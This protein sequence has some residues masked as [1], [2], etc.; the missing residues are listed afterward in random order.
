MTRTFIY[1]RHVTAL[2]LLTLSSLGIADEGLPSLE[3]RWQ[4]ELVAARYQPI[5]LILTITTSA[6]DQYTG[7]LDIPSQFQ[8]GV[9]VNPFSP[10]GNNIT[11]RVPALQVEFYG[12][13]VLNDAGTEVLA[14]EGDWS[15]SGEYVPLRLT[16]A[17]D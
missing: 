12:N 4:G 8:A 3:G 6:D 13:L 9:P 15:Q 17:A 16:P 5:P 1:H 7:A 2:I 11:L 10:R 14:I